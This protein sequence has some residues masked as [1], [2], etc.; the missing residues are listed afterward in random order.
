MK[1]VVLILEDDDSV[2]LMLENTLRDEG[3][4]VVKAASA[5]EF[6]QAIATTAIDLFLMD[7]NLPDG[8]GLSLVKEIRKVSEVGIILLTGLADE[9]DK[10]VGLEIGADDYI[11]KPF[12]L[13]ELKAR[14]NAVYRRT[15]ANRFD[16]A[17]LSSSKTDASPSTQTLRFGKWNLH[18]DSRRLTDAEDREV[19]LTTIEFDLLIALVKNRNRVLTRDQ[20]MTAV[21]GQDW[22]SYDRAVDGVIS[23]LRSKLPVDGTMEHY[24]KTV[25]GVGYMFSCD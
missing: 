14:I 21:K 20:I 19:R 9:I 25:R 4:D 1:L 12:R 2:A 6:H 7:V 18:T 13:R 5:E 17:N 8:S 24:I 11:S 23:R 10:V 3:Y 15:K 22:A 16:M